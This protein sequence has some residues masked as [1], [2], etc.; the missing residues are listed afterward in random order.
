MSSGRRRLLR[1]VAA[2]LFLLAGLAVLPAPAEAA[3]K[4]PD[5]AVDASGTRIALGVERKVVYLKISNLGDETPSDVVVHVRQLS[6]GPDPL[7]VSLLWHSGGGV[8]SA[9]VIS[10]GSTADCR[11]S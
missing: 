1:T 3:K 4:G 7:P 6:Q 9:T 5:L 8:G 11:R 2:A 10:A